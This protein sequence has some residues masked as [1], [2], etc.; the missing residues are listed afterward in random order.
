M[1]PFDKLDTNV[2]DKVVDNVGDKIKKLNLTRQQIMEEIRN[3]PNITQPQLMVIIG[4]GKTAIQNNIA[5]LKKN[6]YIERVGSN[7][8]GYWRAI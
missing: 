3:N 5:F 4:I 1:I 7:K 2:G 8:N 6:S